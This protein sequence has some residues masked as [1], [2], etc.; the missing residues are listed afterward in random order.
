MRPDIYHLLWTFPK[1]FYVKSI[2]LGD[3]LLPDDRIDLTGALAP[4]TIQLA[5]DGGRVQGVVRNS[6]GE[7]VPGAV[8]TMTADP[9]YD[10]WSA[11]CDNA[12][13][14]EI[15]DIAPGD[16][17]LLAFDDAPQGAPQDPDFR[18]PY[19]KTAARLQVLPSTQQTLNLIA[20]P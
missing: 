5:S 11:T 8:V 2:K 3:R 1:G 13:R 9:S 19:E 18:K 17:R 10:F 12:G 16:Y 14:F 6:A 15:R 4:L 7:P 20:I